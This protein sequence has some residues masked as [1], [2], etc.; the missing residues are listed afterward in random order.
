M[1]TL[2][3]H[4]NTALINELWYDSHR[5]LIVKIATEL[6][7]VDKIDSLVEKFLSKPIKIKK[8]KDPNRP[9]RPKTSYL[10]FCEEKR[11]LVKNQHPEFKVGEIMK[12]LG[13]MWKELPEDDKAKYN[14]LYQ[15][16]KARYEEELEE[17]E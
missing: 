7:S 3:F 12:E 4:N 1:E 2:P 10:Y 15:Q 6:D 8:F 5:N 14:D 11:P 9:K 17:Y 16:D 13:K